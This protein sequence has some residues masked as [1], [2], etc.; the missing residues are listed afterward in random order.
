MYL[1]SCKLCGYI[2]WRPLLITVIKN[3]ESLRIL[4]STHT[5]FVVGA[6]KD[7]F[8]ALYCL[9]GSRATKAVCLDATVGKL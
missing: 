1:K 9:E 7:D 6:L 8:Y 3:K 5:V 4:F 2:T